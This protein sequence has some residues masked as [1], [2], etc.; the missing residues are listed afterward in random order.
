MD[1]HELNTGAYKRA[2]TIAGELRDVLNGILATEAT[3][4][5]DNNIICD[6]IRQLATLRDSIFNRT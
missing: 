4:D 1:T 5:T 3:N 2:Y 6:T